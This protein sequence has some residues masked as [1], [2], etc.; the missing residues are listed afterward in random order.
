MKSVGLC[1][2][3]QV[4][5]QLGKFVVDQI[6]DNVKFILAPNKCPCYTE[7]ASEFKDIRFVSKKESNDTIADLVHKSNV[8][9]VFLL[10][11]PFI[12]NETALSTGPTFI[13]THPSLLPYNRGKHPYYWSIVEGT[14]AGV[15]IHL[16]SLNIDEGDILFQEEIYT[17]IT[18]T[19]GSIY[20][21]SVNTMI[22]LFQKSFVYILDEMYSS[23][24]QSFSKCHYGVELKKHSTIDLDREYKAR[25]L[26]NIIRG[27]T[28][29]NNN[30]SSCFIEN[31]TKYYITVNIREANDG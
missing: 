20:Q 19:G 23:Q 1:I 29:D 30:P 13:N 11:W 12:L 2:S 9:I 16:V 17:D 25:D 6:G 3:D 15:S 22:S 8:D 10:W 14:P 5:L 4:G 21:K 24:P 26:I 28:F 31:N 18:D 27:R 7:I